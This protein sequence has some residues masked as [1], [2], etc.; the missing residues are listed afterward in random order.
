MLINYIRTYVIQHSAKGREL[1]ILV[2]NKKK[3]MKSKGAYNPGKSPALYTHPKIK[4]V[5]EEVDITDTNLN[6][7]EVSNIVK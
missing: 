1:K 7:Q 4:K 6:E 5:V 3:A 2:G